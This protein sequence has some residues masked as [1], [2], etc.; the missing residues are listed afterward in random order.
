M[1][2]EGPHDAA[3]GG[4]TRRSARRAGVAGPG[5]AR[6]GARGAEA[7]FPQARPHHRGSRNGSRGG[8]LE[9]AGQAARHPLRGPQEVRCAARN[10]AA[11]ERDP[12]TAAARAGSGGARELGPG[13]HGRSHESCRLRRAHARPRPGSPARGRLRVGP[14]RDHRSRLPAHGGDLEPR[15]G[16]HPGGRR[17]RDRLRR[18]ARWSAARRGC[19]RRAIAPD[20]LRGRDAGARLRHPHRAPGEDAQHPLPHRRRPAPADRGGNQD[21]LPPWCSA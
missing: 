7:Q 2:S 1:T 6:D 3:G 18:S 20:G 21:L 15:E 4:S 11:V 17:L 19:A 16:T 5:T 10:R 12:G 13:R 9:S 8:H 14:A